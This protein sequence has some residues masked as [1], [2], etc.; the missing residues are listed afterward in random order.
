MSR[1][2]QHLG[3]EPKK[4]LVQRAEIEVKTWF[5]GQRGRS[6]EKNAGELIEVTTA[7]EYRFSD[8]QKRVFSKQGLCVRDPPFSSFSSFSMV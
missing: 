1:K 7:T 2:M 3:Q 5:G 8:V 4:K 6:Q